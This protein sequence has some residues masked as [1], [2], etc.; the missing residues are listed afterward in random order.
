MGFSG[1]EEF[2]AS[3]G[4]ELGV[5]VRFLELDDV[6]PYIEHM[7]A[8]DSESGRDGRPHFHVYPTSHVF[9]RVAAKERERRRWTTP[10]TKGGWRRAWGL[11]DGDLI[12][13][14]L[15][16]AGGTLT[17]ELH[18]VEMGMGIVHT[19]H[20]RGGG[21]SLLKTAIDW[22]RR[23]SEIEWIDL[24]VFEENKPAQI[25]YEKFGFE[26]LGRTP[27]RFRVDGHRIDD[28]SMSL[29]VGSEA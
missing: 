26:I 2:G 4:P 23:Q 16:L 20:R 5:T 21:S 12:V 24:G 3:S 1:S 9:D 14:H 15:Y 27:D 22:S 17:S 6:D 11:M 8:A 10:I 13:G 7:I 18:R 28:I 29:Y 19:H 25:L